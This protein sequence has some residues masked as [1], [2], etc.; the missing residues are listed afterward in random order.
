MTRILLPAMA[1][2]LAVGCNST[3]NGK[4]VDG[5]TGQPIMGKPAD[6]GE[7]VQP[8]R[9]VANAVKKGDSGNW[10]QNAEAGMTC[11]TF[12][13]PIGQDGSIS[14]S[15]LC[16]SAT[17][18]KLSIEPDKN[19]FLGE[20]DMLAKGTKVEGPMTIKAWRAPNGTAVNI[21]RKDGTTL[22]PVRSRQKVKSEKITGSEEMVYYPEGIKGVPQMEAGEYLVLSGETNAKLQLYPLVN[23][24]ARM[25]KTE[26]T[27]VKMQ[28]WSYIGTKFVDDE[29]FERV[30][31]SVDSA[32]I[33]TVENSGHIVKFIPTAAVGDK[34]R[35]ALWVEGQENAYLID[36]GAKG[37]MPSAPTAEEEGENAGGE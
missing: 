30:S 8:N 11:M 2:A 15:G 3:V 9:L 32:K 6:A 21:L 18:Y 37:E 1:L 20:T 34:G 14:L 10:E 16:L 31:A 7:E 29:T 33:Q 5:L 36:I 23:S 13:S 17:D 28:P 35:Y 22:D 25:F 12:S 24:G 19:Y 4:V 27:E 26:E